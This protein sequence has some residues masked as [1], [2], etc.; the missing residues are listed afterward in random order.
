MFLVSCEEVGD[1]VD[2]YFL[3]YFFQN[4][5]ELSSCLDELTL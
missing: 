3:T 1:G 4:L 5:Q 2:F